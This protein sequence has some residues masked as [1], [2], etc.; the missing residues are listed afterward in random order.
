MYVFN[1]E[2]WPRNSALGHSFIY[3][4]KLLAEIVNIYFVVSIGQVTSNLFV[5]II[6]NA[7]Y[8]EILKI[9]WSS[10]HFF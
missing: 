10:Q 2:Q 9:L 4:F 7:S 5:H 1:N 8:E 3:F 6:C